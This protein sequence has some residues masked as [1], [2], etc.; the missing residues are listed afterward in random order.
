M[1]LKWFRPNRPK[2]TGCQSHRPVPGFCDR[3]CNLCTNVMQAVPQRIYLQARAGV[4]CRVRP[5]DAPTITPRKT[6]PLLRYPSDNQAM[7]SRTRIMDACWQRLR[8]FNTAARKNPLIYQ[9]A[10]KTF[11]NAPAHVVEGTYAGATRPTHNDTNKINLGTAKCKF[12]EPR[13]GRDIADF[14]NPWSTKT[15]CRPSQARTKPE[16]SARH[17]LK[18][19]AQTKTNLWKDPAS[20][21]TIRPRHEDDVLGIRH[22]SWNFMPQSW[23]FSV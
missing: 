14:Q 13:P 19:N 1:T 4:E 20:V 8:I 15:A 23:V 11:K 10:Q 9:D 6:G 16:P 7:K 21:F 22:W 3:S 5:T 12:W 2:S 17:G 18:A